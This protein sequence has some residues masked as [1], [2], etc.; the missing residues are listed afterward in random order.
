MASECVL[1]RDSIKLELCVFVCLFCVWYNICTYVWYMH[2]C[3]RCVFIHV[4][5][6]MWYNYVWFVNVCV[7]ACVNLWACVYMLKCQCERQR[8]MWVVPL[9]HIFL[10]QIS[11]WL[12]LDQGRYKL[13]PHS[14]ALTPTVLGLQ[15]RDLF[16]LSEGSSSLISASAF[17]HWAISLD[18][19]PSWDTKPRILQRALNVCRF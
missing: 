8:T 1:N 13:S 19:Y 14:S 15:T 6:C 11:H 9:S 16:W 12:Y 3:V 7:Y 17:S 10:G 2:I 5:T 18:C 4:H